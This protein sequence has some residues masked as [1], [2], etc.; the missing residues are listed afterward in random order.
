MA[1]CQSPLPHSFSLL[2]L[3]PTVAPHKNIRRA[4]LVAEIK[5]LSRAVFCLYCDYPDAFGKSGHECKQ[6]LPISNIWLVMKAW[7]R[8]SSFSLA[9][10]SSFEAD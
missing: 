5:D 1:K 2:L 8:K 9:L 10:H 4:M 7:K 3:L 6:L